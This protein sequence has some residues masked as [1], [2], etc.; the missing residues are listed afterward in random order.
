M[1]A[2]AALAN[3]TGRNEE[4]NSVV[5]R[6]NLKWNGRNDLGALVSLLY[7]NRFS[8]MIGELKVA[9]ESVPK[10][11]TDYFRFDILTGLRP[12][13]ACKA[14]NMLRK[15]P[16]YLNAQMQV[17]GHFKTPELFIRNTKKCFISVVD[18]ETLEIA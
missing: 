6:Y 4:W 10:E 9:F 18:R 15:N 3:F 16:G 13:E 17:L 2:L 11:Y 14:L 1:G 7:T 5:T 8:D 12:D